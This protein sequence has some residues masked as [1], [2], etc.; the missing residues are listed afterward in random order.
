MLT[1]FVILVLLLIGLLAYKA[2]ADILHADEWVRK[3]R[4][5]Q[6]H[7]AHLTKEGYNFD[8]YKD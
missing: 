2:R 4:N 1:A 7:S 5:R 8:P 6:F 3:E